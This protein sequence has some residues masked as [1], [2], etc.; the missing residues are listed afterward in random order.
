M[1]AVLAVAVV[2]GVT[3]A[4]LIGVGTTPRTGI[5]TVQIREV[6]II[7]GEITKSFSIP[8]QATWIDHHDG[9]VNFVTLRR[10]G[11]G[12]KFTVSPLSGE[13]ATGSTS[14]THCT[15]GA[16][17]PSPNHVNQMRELQ[18]FFDG[19]DMG[20]ELAGFNTTA[21]NAPAGATLK[22]SH[23]TYGGLASTCISI[24]DS[25]AL[26]Q[27]WCAARNGLVTYGD[28]AGRVFSLTSFTSTVG[29]T[30]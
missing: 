21:A 25:G 22:F 29:T 11:P 13:K 9:S 5:T 20:D 7:Q 27:R 4:N 24:F 26:S 28:Y 19:T 14:S 1:G 2:A 17:C 18:Q 3:L 10:A 15:K 6:N 23:E 30:D 8:I 16:S 12:S